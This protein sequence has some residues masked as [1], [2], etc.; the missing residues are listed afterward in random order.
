MLLLTT[1]FSQKDVLPRD[2][3]VDEG[4]YARV[5]VGDCARDNVVVAGAGDDAGDRDDTGVDGGDAGDGYDAGVNRRD[6]AGDDRGGAGAEFDAE[7]RAARNDLVE[8]PPVA[9][10]VANPEKPPHAEP[11]PPPDPRGV[12]KNGRWYQTSGLAKKG[13]KN[14]WHAKGRQTKKPQS[15]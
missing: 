8:P 7:A 13:R 12:F 14:T 5:D 2:V 4:L 15:W 11:P 1:P 10:G 6:D 9:A 3:A